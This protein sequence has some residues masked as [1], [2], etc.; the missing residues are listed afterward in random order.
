ML[1]AGGGSGSD[2]AAP[3][4]SEGAHPLKQPPPNV[5]GSFAID[6]PPF[7]LAS[8]SRE[9]AGAASKRSVPSLASAST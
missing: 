2:E 8:S 6:V 5:V 3:A 1:V 9:G 4:V 7:T